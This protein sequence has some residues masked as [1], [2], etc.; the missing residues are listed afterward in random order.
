VH[1]LGSAG[2]KV[3]GTRA[4]PPI[5]T[6]TKRLK[7][8]SD[9]AMVPDRPRPAGLPDPGQAPPLGFLPAGLHPYQRADQVGDVGPPGSHALDDEHRAP[10]PNLGWIPGGARPSPAGESSLVRPGETAPGSRP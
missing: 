3:P 5:C 7:V 10:G 8:A 6:F 9:F 4:S 1:D 2:T